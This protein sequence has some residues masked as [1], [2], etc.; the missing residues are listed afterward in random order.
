MK[1]ARFPVLRSQ[2]ALDESSGMH[3]LYV[4]ESGDIGR[5][6]PQ[7]HT[8]VLCGLMVHHADWHEAQAEF[9]KMRQRLHADFGL[10]MQAELHASELLG[11]S[12]HHFKLDR[13]QRVKIALH[14]LE[15]IR[16]QRTLTAVRVTVD[17]RSSVEEI[18]P[19]AWRSLLCAAKAKITGTRHVTCASQGLIIVCDDHR[20]APASS[21]L[22]WVKCE[23]AL[24]GLLLDQPFG[25]DSKASEFLQACDLL[26]YLTK[27]TNEPA[28]FFRQNK[29][30]WLTKRCDKLFG[31]ANLSM[32]LK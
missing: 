31:D 21:W 5:H 6:N 12:P 32:T 28:G 9:E 11:K 27:Q 22:E 4:D 18:L 17:K 30:R 8:F 20:T 2:P 29:S 26:A 10:P 19:A 13:M 23:L 24:P 3:L 7:N 16:N 15:T 1:P 14:M 25:R